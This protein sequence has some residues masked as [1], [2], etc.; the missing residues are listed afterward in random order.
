MA[1]AGI[2]S[3]H[4]LVGLDLKGKKQTKKKER[5]YVFFF[6]STVLGDNP[7]SF[8]RGN[9]RSLWLKNASVERSLKERNHVRGK[10]GKKTWEIKFIIIIIFP[11]FVVVYDKTGAPFEEN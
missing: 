1:L 8:W 7:P 11:P 3:P 6:P 9:N 5:I 10:G 4:V 2:S